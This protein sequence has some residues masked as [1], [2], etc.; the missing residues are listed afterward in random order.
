MWIIFFMASFACFVLGLLPYLRKLHFRINGTLLQA[1]V[2]SYYEKREFIPRAG[3]HHSFYA[4][5][6]YRVDGMEYKTQKAIQIP[7]RSSVGEY[8]EI[9][10]LKN[11]PQRI[12]PKG[13]NI[14]GSA[15]HLVFILIA[16]M[17]FFMGFWAN[18][19][20]LISLF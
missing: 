13:Y 7:Q 10:Y 14:R 6:S 2:C 17:F 18:I 15:F 1:M 11:N 3:Y 16:I 19:D 5:L 9:Y 4:E 20:L 12:S 8:I